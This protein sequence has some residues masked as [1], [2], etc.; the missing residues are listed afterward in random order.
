MAT[1]KRRQDRGGRWEVRYRD[2]EGKQ[3]ARLFDRKEGPGGAKEF[4]IGIEHSKLAGTYVDPSAG[5]VTFR[6]FAEEWRKVQVHR[7]GTAQSV[8]Q[9]L[10]VHVYPVIG[11]RPIAAI[12]PSEIQGMVAGFGAPTTR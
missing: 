11:D 1:I 12:R 8:E 4:V 3:K 6:S 10:R 7:P 5:R 2:P 9:Q